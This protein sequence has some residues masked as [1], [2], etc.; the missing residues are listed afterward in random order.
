MSI[1]AHTDSVDDCSEID[2]CAGNKVC[3]V[4]DGFGRWPLEGSGV[5]ATT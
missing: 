3:W 1:D 2:I 4:F 5:V